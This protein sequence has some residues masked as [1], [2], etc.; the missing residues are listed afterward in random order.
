MS[1]GLPLQLLI[2]LRD[3]FKFKWTATA[4]KY[5]DTHI[6]PK[7]SQIFALNFP[8]L[9]TAVRALLAK[10]NTGLHSWFGR[11]NIL[12][13]CILPKFLYLLQ[14]L[15]VQ[16]PFSYFDQASALFFDFIWAHKRPRL[17]R[18]Q[19]T[20][21]KTHRGLAVPD[22]RKY[23]YATHLTR[24][25]DWNR[26][27]STKLWT[28]LEQTRCDIPLN[29]I[30]WC[31]HVLPREVKK[32]HPL[33]GMT[34]RT[35]SFLFTHYRL[36]SFDSPLRPILGTPEFTPGYT[37]PIFYSLRNFNYFQAS[38]FLRDGRW[39]NTSELMSL[40]GP[41]RLDYWRAFQLKHF[42]KSLPPPRNFCSNSDHL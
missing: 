17:N 14:A 41:F 37:D 12:K 28:R 9:L 18:R 32:N 27:Q 29:R 13:M 34:A 11:C 40:V 25:I 7:I 6:P 36:S 26:H 19:L 42:L 24:L 38:H 20:L 21:P 23:Y 10:W 5:L 1:V 16:I 8:P 3:N 31:H 15:P 22:L 35:C 30:P 2:T 4:L 39:P 33:I